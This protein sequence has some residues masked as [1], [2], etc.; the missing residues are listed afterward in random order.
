[1]YRSRFIP[2]PECGSLVERGEPVPHVCDSEQ[3]LRQR[4]NGWSQEVDRL[5]QDLAEHLATPTG[6]FEAWMAWHHVRRRC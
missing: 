2:C 4:L 6:R 3:L 1:V 5:E